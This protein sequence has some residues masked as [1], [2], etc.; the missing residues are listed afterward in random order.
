MKR[1][2]WALS[3]LLLSFP[4][5]SEEKIELYTVDIEVRP[6]GDLLIREDIRVVAEGNAIRRGIYR[7]F[8][9]DY[10]DRLG[11]RVR[12]DFEVVDVYRDGVS[13]PYSVK[14]E[15]GV[16]AVYV[17]S[18]NIL[19]DPAI[20]TYTLIFRTSRQL[21]FF[22]EVDELYFNAIGGDWSFQIDSAAVTVHLPPGASPVQYAAYSGY[23]GETGCACEI[24]P[25]ADR[26]RYL[27]TAPLLPNQQLTVAVGWPKGFVT[28]PSQLKKAGYLLRDN[29]NVLVGLFGLLA[30]FLIYLR[31][32]RRVGRDPRKGTII[33]LFNPPEGHSPAGCHYLMN[34]GFGNRSFTATLVE[35]AVKGYMVISHPKGRKYKLVKTG[36]NEELL[37]PVQQSIARHL[38]GAGDSLELEQKHYKSFQAAQ[39]ALQKDLAARY[40]PGFFRFNTKSTLMGFIP[41]VLFIVLMFLLTDSAWIFSIIILILFIVLFIVFGLLMKAP[42][43]EGRKL[44]DEM[45]GFRM[46]LSTTEKDRLNRLEEPEVTPELFEMYLPY[47]I[48]LGV[49]NK[50]GAKLEQHLAATAMQPRQPAWY[51]AAP[52]RSFSPGLFS[53]SLGGAFTRAV[54]SSSSAP[55]SSSGS[56]GGGRS[57]GGGGGGG[58]GGW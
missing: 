49:E 21:G 23:A 11:Q 48:A 37:S 19:L 30:T 13:E 35:M 51:H 6:D 17:G 40:Q 45:E 7:L 52:G 53:S 2:Y 12:V 58:G 16:S 28:E 22:D 27:T 4:A 39:A 10:R 42:T 50:W 1:I 34:M 24:V 54:S 43:P 18:E 14:R 20:Y 36:K 44:M 38:F 47:A 31:N 5:W 46:F 8:P 33:P 56:G 9:T 41:G 57:G 15:G 29:D 25:E 55:G 32:W 3:L 26:I